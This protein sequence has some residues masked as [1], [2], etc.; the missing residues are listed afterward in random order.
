[1]AYVTMSKNI[2]YSML[3]I[4]LIA[5][6]IRRSDV[7]D[8]GTREANDPGTNSDGI[9]HDGQR[10]SGGRCANTDIAGRP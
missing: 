9:S 5:N 2:K 10:I 7:D 4:I 3:L 1:M 6:S 8:I